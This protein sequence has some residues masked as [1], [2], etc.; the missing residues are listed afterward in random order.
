MPEER[1]IQMLIDEIKELKHKLDEHG[2]KMGGLACQ[3]HEVKIGILWKGFWGIIVANA[4]LVFD[5]LK[6]VF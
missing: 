6:R 4:M 3:T 5:Y 1:L 2:K